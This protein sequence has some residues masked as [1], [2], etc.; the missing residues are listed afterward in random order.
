MADDRQT[1]DTGSAGRV[2]ATLRGALVAV[3]LVATIA[4]LRIWLRL[5]PPHA[6][7]ASIIE[8]AGREVLRIAF[9]A[10]MILFGLFWA[11]LITG[12]FVVTIADGIGASDQARITAH[13]LAMGA[14]IVAI[15]AVF[16]PLSGSDD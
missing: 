14:I 11:Y 13:R 7:R 5:G 8:R 2:M 4:F 12:I 3:R 15:A 16:L 6:A 10:F 9:T 1:G